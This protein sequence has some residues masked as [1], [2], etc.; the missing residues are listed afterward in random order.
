M[1]L[2]FH[3]RNKPETRRYLQKRGG[4]GD[5]RVEIEVLKR[6]GRGDERGEGWE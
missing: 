5:E 4:R 3:P 2:T 1:P 6:G